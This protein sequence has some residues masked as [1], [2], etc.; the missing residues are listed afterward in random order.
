MRDYLN[1]WR[2]GVPA[3]RLFMIF[4]G[5]VS[6]ILTGRVHVGVSRRPDRRLPQPLTEFSK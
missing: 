1:S 2:L 6:L 4:L 5:S 3:S